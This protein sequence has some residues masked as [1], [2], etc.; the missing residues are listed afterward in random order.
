MADSVQNRPEVDIFPVTAER[1]NDLETLFGPKGAYSGCWCMF[2]RLKRTDFNKMSGEGRK[3]ML[4][5]TTFRNEVPGVLAYIGDQPIGWC[6]VGP[7]ESF[8]ALENSRILKRLDDTPVWSIVCFYV[9]KAFRK[10]G[11]ML[12]LVRGAVGYAGQE[13]ARVIEAYPIDMQTHQLAGKK[14]TGYS[15][16]MG[17]ASI[18]RAAGFVRV[19]D[20]SETQLIMRYVM[21]DDT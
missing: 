8:I 11:M 3:A 5:D 18:F 4:K 20:A 21:K 10:K 12:E 7:R 13:G 6:S 16:Y 2:W 1:W 14:L 19:A 9:A 17:I 15:G